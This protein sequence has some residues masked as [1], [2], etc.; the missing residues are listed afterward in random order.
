M[1]E[2]RQI[3]R[4]PVEFNL[5]KE[6]DRLAYEYVKSLPNFAGTVKAGFANAQRRKI[7][8]AQH[9]TAQRGTAQ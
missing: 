4:K 7:A 8:A 9:S 6:E 1:A 5:N 2:S 3:V